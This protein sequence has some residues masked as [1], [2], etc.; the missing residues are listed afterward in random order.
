[1]SSIFNRNATE[2][3]NKRPTTKDL[4][5]TV[6]DCGSLA[7]LFGSRDTSLLNLASVPQNIRRTLSAGRVAQRCTYALWIFVSFVTVMHVMYSSKVVP[8][9]I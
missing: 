2:I 5:T 4:D 7:R 1:M 9:T 8:V 6:L 3:G